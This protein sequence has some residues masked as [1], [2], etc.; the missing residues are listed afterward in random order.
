M[1]KIKR[2]L[3]ASA[4]SFVLCLALLIGTTFAWFTD[5]VTNVGNR[6]SAGEFE[7]DF[8]MDKSQDGNYTSIANGSGDIFGEKTVD[9]KDGRANGINWEPGKTEIVFLAIQN[10]G[11]LALKYDIIFKIIDCGLADAL[12]YAIIDG[13]TAQSAAQLSSWAD[14]EALSGI[15][16][17]RVEAGVKSTGQTVLD[18]IAYDSTAKNQTKYFA[19]A[20][21]MREDAGNEFI[22]KSTS[23]DVTV[24]ASQVPAESDSFSNQYDKDA[25]FEQTPEV[26][27]LIFSENYP[28]IVT[29]ISESFNGETL[30]IPEGVTGIAEKAFKGQRTIKTLSAI[31]NILYW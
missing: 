19:L 13:A 27:A 24:A 14:I 8:L 22:S 5:S 9:Y 26:S 18:E 15:T 12:E 17:G 4:L 7:I 21:H 2:S 23:I 25:T 31:D 6:I 1:K 29:G 30:I 3:L 28:T 10:K 16:I 20:V 11:S